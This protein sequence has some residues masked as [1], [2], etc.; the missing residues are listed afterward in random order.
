MKIET[1]YRIDQLTYNHF[2]VTTRWY[3]E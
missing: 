2:P 3:P 1:R